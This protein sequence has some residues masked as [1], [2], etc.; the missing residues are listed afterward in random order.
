MI[1]R[2]ESML[3]MVLPAL[4]LGWVVIDTAMGWGPASQNI[5]V[6]APTVQTLGTAE[7]SAPEATFDASPATNCNVR[8]A[9]GYGAFET[10]QQL[11]QAG[12]RFS[13]MVPNG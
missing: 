9:R 7:M 12:Q 3:A 2:S 11:C 5:Q 10:M 4:A 1:V 8:H 6:A 13:I